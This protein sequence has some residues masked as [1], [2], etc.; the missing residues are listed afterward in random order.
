MGAEWVRER[1][2][3]VHKGLIAARRGI[4][5]APICEP[6][7][8]DKERVALAE[9]GVGIVHVLQ[10][11][12]T[13][14]EDL[15]RLKGAK[16]AHEQRLAGGR[17]RVARRV[18]NQPAAHI[19]EG[20]VRLAHEGGAARRAHDRHEEGGLVRPLARV[21]GAKRAR[22]FEQSIDLGARDRV[23]AVLGVKGARG[24]ASVGRHVEA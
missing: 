15:G 1:E 11:E 23:L 2:E 6:V 14:W 24:A 9:D 20:R 18:D 4:E 5:A 3:R 8:I 19:A 12:P 21:V 17:L 10:D 22:E 13:Y 16:R 7:K